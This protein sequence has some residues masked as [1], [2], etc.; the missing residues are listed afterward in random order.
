MTKSL[1]G[2]L[3]LKHKFIIL[4]MNEGA[5]IKVHIEEFNSIVTDLENV[6][7]KIDDEDQALQLLCSLPPLYMHFCETWLYGREFI[8][9]KDEKAALLLKDILDK[10]LASGSGEGQDLE[11]FVSRGHPK[12]KNHDA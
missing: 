1:I 8:T 7:V 9:L 3:H 4:R 10:G 5:S 2:K 12:Q 6:D 11:D